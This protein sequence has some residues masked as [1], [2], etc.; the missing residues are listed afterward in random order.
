MQSSDGWWSG[1]PWQATQ[2]G[3]FVPVVW[4]VATL[5]PWQPLFTHVATDEVCASTG[6]GCCVVKSLKWQSEHTR[7]GIFPSPWHAMHFGGVVWFVVG[8]ASI[9]AMLVL[10]QPTAL[11]PVGATVWVLSGVVEVGCDG[12]LEGEGAKEPMWHEVHRAVTAGPAGTAWHAAHLGPP[13][14][15]WIWSTGL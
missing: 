9:D 2:P 6:A 10:W 14:T 12:L 11:Q 15:P 13:A 8:I 5:E 1:L 7:E 3:G 4:I